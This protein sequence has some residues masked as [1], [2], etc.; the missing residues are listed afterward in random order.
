MKISMKKYSTNVRIYYKSGDVYSFTME[1]SSLSALDKDI[2]T[3][4]QNR[5]SEV[6][7]ICFE[8]IYMTMEKKVE[9][10]GQYVQFTDK[11]TNKYFGGINPKKFYKPLD[12]G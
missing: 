2:V 9:N 4:A 10:K 3:Y 12:I 5:N 11:I 7:A 1:N 8:P 6:E